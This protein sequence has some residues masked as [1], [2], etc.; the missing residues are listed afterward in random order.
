MI[1]IYVLIALFVCL[2]LCFI[3]NSNFI[4]VQNGDNHYWNQW[5]L[6]NDGTFEFSR[7][8]ENYIYTYSYNSVEKIDI[9]YNEG[10]RLVKQKRSATIAVIDSG[11]WYNHDAFNDSI[12][13]NGGRF[14]MMVSIMII[15]GILM[16]F[17]VGISIVIIMI[18]VRGQTKQ[19]MVR[20][21][22]ERY[23]RMEK[24]L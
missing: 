18:L 7:L 4:F 16:M 6:D 9:G 8:D 23:V 17:M 24:N 14:L 22:L 10:I 12:W 13:T 2:I 5:A 19:I 20:I 11:V 15:M 3:F 21:L 1:C